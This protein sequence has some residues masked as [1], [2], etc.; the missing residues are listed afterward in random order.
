MLIGYARVSTDDQNPTLQTDALTKEGCEKVY[1]DTMTGTR[2]KRPQL[3]KALEHVQKGD[4][5]V[6]WRLDRL[7]RNLKHLIEL[8][9]QFET[10]S[11]SFK[12][13]TEAIDT[14]TS[15]GRLIFYIFGAMAEFESNII[16]ERTNAG[17][18]AARARGR[19]GGRRHKLSAKQRTHAVKLH[20]DGDHAVKE[21]CEIMKIS[22]ATLYNYL[23]AD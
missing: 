19:L 15:G 13:L 16:K 18:K 9:T 4:T 6:V 12:S 17:L 2:A 7:G 11:I 1:T 23:K 3:D 8:V 21:I 22:R 5:F 14:T 20:K 10:R